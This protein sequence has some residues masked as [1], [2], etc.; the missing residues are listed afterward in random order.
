MPSAA[1]GTA[2][3]PD[4]VVPA[5]SIV[6]VAYG[7]RPYSERCLNSLDEAFGERIGRDVELVLVDNASPDDTAELFRSWED[8]A[9]VL[10]LPE[11]RNFAGGYNAG[12]R[13]ASGEV[14]ALLNNDTLVPPGALEA[15]AAEASD[16]AVGL[17]G[18]RL[19]YPDG[20]LQ[21]GGFG[22]RAGQHGLIPYHLF[23]WDRADLPAARCSFDLDSVTAACIAARRELF[24]ELGGFDEGFVNGWEDVDLCLRV[25][26][27]GLRVVYRGDVHV[28]HDEGATS[29]GDYAAGDNVHLFSSRWGDAL[30]PDEELLRSVFDA[31]ANPLIDH[32]V[33]GARHPGGASIVVEGHLSGLSPEGDEARALLRA[34]EAAGHEPAGRDL[35]DAAVSPRLSDLERESLTRALT[36]PARP[37]ARTL[38]VEASGTAAWPPPIP[39]CR[40]GTGGRGVLAI[41]PAHDLAAA[42]RALAGLRLATVVVLP[43]ARTP[44]I[45]T[46]V[47]A[48]L[49]GAELLNPLSSED[50]FAELAGAFDVVLCA[51]PDDVRQRR[52]LIAAATGTAPVLLHPGPAGAILDVTPIASDPEAVAAAVSDIGDGGAR[53]ARRALVRDRCDLL[54]VGEL[55]AAAARAPSD[56]LP[57]RERPSI[58]VV[59]ASPPTPDVNSAS[60]RL[61]RLLELMLD[62]GFD[63]TFVGRDGRD[64][65]AQLAELD[66]LGIEAYAT[67]PERLAARGQVVLAPAL[68]LPAILRERFH[69]IAW[70][71]TWH[72]AEQYLPE[73]RR[74]SPLTRVVVDSEDVHFLREL[75]GA[76]L[77]GDAAAVECAEQ[78]RVREQA[79]YRQADTLVAVSEQDAAVL[80]QLAPGLPT[81]VISNIHDPEP[82]GPGFDARDG[83]LFVG[84]FWHA[85]NVDAVLWLCR[86]VLPLVRERLPSVRMRIVGAG[87]PPELRALADD[88]VEIAGQVPDLGP[89]LRRAR[90]SLAP[91]RYGAG[92]KGKVG[93]A[94]A[95]G[96]PVV[97]TSVGAEG[98]GI[99]DGRHALVADSPQAFA[100]AIVS[101]HEQPRLW[102]ALRDAGRELIAAQQGRARA[103]HALSELDERLRP[104][105][106]FMATPDWDDPADVLAAVEPYVERFTPQDRV[107]LA[108]CTG[109][110]GPSPGDAFAAVAVALATLGRDPA[111]VPDMVVTELN[112]GRHPLPRELHPRLA[113][114][115]P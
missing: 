65:A 107:S 91:L 72:V 76:E 73:L 97:T 99:E 94:M 37:L 39:A 67:D 48:R 103:A 82:E 108:L 13:A 113:P 88:F 12:A 87:A 30:E 32:G 57:D 68:D 1:G 41:L 63:V 111:Q 59:N 4:E 17:V 83:L 16:P 40:A 56:R 7:K 50:A 104:L 115:T 96:L 53:A 62:Q 81:A 23:Q 101:A 26:S 20:R 2:D 10:L 11:N 27:R 64:H 60:V 45:E 92:V 42:A 100:E 28:I 49:P 25:R 75:R 18:V 14:V 105:T 22:W 79:V 77:S 3:H 5:L 51:D 98:M 61:R 29:G 52:A 33:R 31:E 69:D 38:T 34:L 8:R 86:E 54:A 36:R 85:P 84:S 6:V 58:L 95:H 46:L 9:R 112:P 102:A 70:L 89:D 47:A 19:A 110:G 44:Q 109:P 21:H 43:T 74:H 80:A 93:E 106:T 35:V 90:V 15:L 66:A 78:T 114:A 71:V 55:A 24:L